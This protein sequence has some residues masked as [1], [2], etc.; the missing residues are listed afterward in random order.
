MPDYAMTRTVDLTYEDA[1]E[2]VTA[3]LK[4]EGFG[5]LTE[6][7]VK[8]TLRKKLDAD[9]R[10]YKILGACNPPL[11]RRAL[12]AELEI[13]TMLPCNVC[14]WEDG[15]RAVVSAFNP[16]EVFPA[17]A[18]PALSELAREVTERLRRVLDRL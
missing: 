17:S 4:E 1:L 9:F 12:E 11:A 16:A 8:D 15:D 13:G 18:S 6:I 7:D 10:K 14:V 5:V 3:E 2:R